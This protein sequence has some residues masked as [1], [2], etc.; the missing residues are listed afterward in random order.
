[1]I[2]LVETLNNLLL[3]YMV[4]LSGVRLLQESVDQTFDGL[5]GFLCDRCDEKTVLIREPFTLHPDG[6]GNGWLTME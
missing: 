3:V 4:F 5:E 1:V 2:V 6:D